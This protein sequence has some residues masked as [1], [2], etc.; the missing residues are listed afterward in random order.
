MKNISYPFEKEFR[1]SQRFSENPQIYS[2]FN[3][4][5]HNG[6]DFAIPEGTPILA[7][8]DG[9]VNYIGYDEDGYG[10][11]IRINH[12][13]FQTLYAHGK[14]VICKQIGIKVKK[15]DCVLISGN[16]GFS[17]G[18]HLHFGLREID[19]KGS[20]LNYENGYLG[21]VDPL[22][23]LNAQEADQNASELKEWEKQAVD[24]WLDNGLLQDGN[25]NSDKAWFLEI[26]RKYHI[27]NIEPLQKSALLM[28]NI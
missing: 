6:L 13:G 15:G 8:D 5:G 2:Q 21:Y 10:H 14:E 3:L 7:V 27:Q 16:T 1:I 24:Y 28:S 11:Y 26:L 9:V 4:A 25:I 22:P 19:S 18:A 23:W 17:T 20:V 12:N